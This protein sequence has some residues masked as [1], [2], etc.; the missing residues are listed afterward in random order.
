ME[1]VFSFSV[2]CI[3]AKIH[4]ATGGKDVVPIRLPMPLQLVGTVELVE[5]SRLESGLPHCEGA[6]GLACKKF[7][8][9]E[10]LARG[11]IQMAT[12]RKMVSQWVLR[13][14]QTISVVNQH[15]D[16]QEVLGKIWD[17]GG[18]VIKGKIPLERPAC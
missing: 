17:G 1:C 6:V 13:D 15:H 18:E 7:Q 10:V 5:A 2:V 9:L 3:Q 12:C 8:P 11:P 4:K 16:P 14:V